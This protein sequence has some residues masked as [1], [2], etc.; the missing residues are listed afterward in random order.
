MSYT[1]YKPCRSCG[2]PGGR[3]INACLLI[4]VNFIVVVVVLFVVDRDR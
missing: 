4:F 2:V 3:I 1:V